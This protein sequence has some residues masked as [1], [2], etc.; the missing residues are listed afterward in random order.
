MDVQYMASNPPPPANQ[1]GRTDSI[2]SRQTA[3]SAAVKRAGGCGGCVRAVGKTVTEAADFLPLFLNVGSGSYQRL[4]PIKSTPRRF[5][6]GVDHDAPKMDQLE[7]CRDSARTSGPPNFAPLPPRPVLGF[8]LCK[9]IVC[10]AKRGCER[11]G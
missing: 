8:V 7:I 5:Q 10:N 1:P 4:S 2:V 3:F 11:S 9:R 6:R